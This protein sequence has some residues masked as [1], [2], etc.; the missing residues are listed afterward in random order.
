[1]KLTEK[2][3][4]GAIPQNSICSS[5]RII[6]TTSARPES[7]HAH[8]EFKIVLKSLYWGKLLVHNALKGFGH[9]CISELRSQT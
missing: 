6:R 3:A 2:I 9:Q 7:L 1:M 4:R 5:I 8:M